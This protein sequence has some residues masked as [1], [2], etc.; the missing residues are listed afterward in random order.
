M[1]FP[2]ICWSLDCVKFETLQGDAPRTCTI[3]RNLNRRS[4]SSDCGPTGEG[5]GV[6]KDS[7]STSTQLP[8]SPA[9][10]TEAN[11]ESENGTTSD[12]CNVTTGTALASFQGDRPTSIPVPVEPSEASTPVPVEPSEASTPVPVEPSEASTPVPVEPSEASTP[13]PVEPS[14]ASTPEINSQ[15]DTSVECGNSKSGDDVTTGRVLFSSPE[16]TCTTN[17]NEHN[18]NS[19]EPTLPMEK[20][21]QVIQLFQF[22]AVYYSKTYYIGKPTAIQDG[23]FVFTFLHKMGA[24]E[25][26]GQIERTLIISAGTEFLGDRSPHWGRLN[27][28]HSKI[29]VLVFCMIIWSV[30]GTDEP[31]LELR[32]TTQT[33]KQG[34]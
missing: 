2:R 18:V 26:V 16:Q 31:N 25:F 10:P 5:S 19:G 29:V 14:E 23:L 24:R 30:R 17:Q 21:E 12:V 11:T 20:L 1:S 27:P 7:G 3:R 22:Y 8:P 28:L 15:D 9:C 4:G 32:A 13:V 34:M 33:H 6:T